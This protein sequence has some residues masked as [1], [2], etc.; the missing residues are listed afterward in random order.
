MSLSAEGPD[1]AAGAPPK[2]PKGGKPPVGR[3]PRARIPRDSLSRSVIVDA[4]ITI[5]MRDG[6]D[7]LTFQA[8]GNELGAHATS[9]YRHFRDKDEFLLEVIDTLRERSYGAA[10]VSSDD[11]R[12]DL[13]NLAANIR[14]HYMRYAPFAHDMSVRSTHRKTE[15]ANVEFALDA[16]ARAG[17]TP[18]DAILYVRVFGNYVRAMS[19][20]E[21]AISSLDDDLRAKDRIEMQIGAANL[22]SDEFPHLVAASTS[23]LAFDDPRVFETGIE[24]IL[25]AIERQAGSSRS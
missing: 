17:L 6:L 14:E 11:W 24:A 25:D 20:F 7:G 18:E 8:L 15:F 5:A 16:L 1:T 4:G 3:A 2:P 13:R 22:S 9:V 19:S 10:L 23:L 12:A 21:A